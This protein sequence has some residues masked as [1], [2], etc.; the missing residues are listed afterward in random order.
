MAKTD[1]TNGSYLTPALQNTYWGTT[2]ATGHVHDGVDD[3]GHC[4]KITLTDITDSTTGSFNV[5]VSSSYFTPDQTASW[6]FYKLGKLCTI[7]TTQLDGTHAGSSAIEIHPT[8]G[9]WPSAIIP[10]AT[11]DVACN[12]I[13]TGKQKIGKLRVTAD[14]T[15]RIVAYYPADANG[16]LSSSGFDAGANKGVLSSI[17]S[18]LTS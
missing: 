9:T 13:S 10:T 15:T 14:S 16:S 2:G 5:S 3:D 11:I 12:V 7:L 8:S 4:P 1:W 18:Y 6:T 17:Y